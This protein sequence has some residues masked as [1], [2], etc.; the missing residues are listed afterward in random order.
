[1]F[2]F[3]FCVCCYVCDVCFEIEYV[4]CDVVVYRVYRAF[5][6]VV[7]VKINFWNF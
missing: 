6:V 1:M 2:I 7:D 4:R 5:R 3:G